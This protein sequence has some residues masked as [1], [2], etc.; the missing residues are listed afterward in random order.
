MVFLNARP[1]MKHGI[2][3]DPDQGIHLSLQYPS[4]NTRRAV[5]PHDMGG[6]SKVHVHVHTYTG[7]P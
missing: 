2:A 1:Y 3:S 7:E 4:T 5:T 6:D